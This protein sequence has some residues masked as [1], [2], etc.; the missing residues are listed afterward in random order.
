MIF[1][2]TLLVIS[3]K[4]NTMTPQKLVKTVTRRAA[5]DLATQHPRTPSAQ[6]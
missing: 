5:T 2:L 1:L 6:K 4:N 3:R